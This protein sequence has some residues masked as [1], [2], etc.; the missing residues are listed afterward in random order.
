[1]IVNANIILGGEEAEAASALLGYTSG[2][3]AAIR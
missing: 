2:N 3:R 1:M